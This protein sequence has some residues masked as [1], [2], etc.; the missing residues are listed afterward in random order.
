MAY[1]EYTMDSLETEF[2]IY[3]QSDDHYAGIEPVAVTDWLRESVR[4]GLYRARGI[5][6]EKARSELLI[7]PVLVEAVERCRDTAT[8]FSGVDFPVDSSR[9]LRGVVDFLISLSREQFVVRSPVIAIVEAKNENIKSGIA[10]CVAEMVAA[11]VFNRDRGSDLRTVFGVV[12]T[13]T[14][15]QFM[16]LVDETVYIEHNEYYLKEVEKVVAI[17]IA[18]IR[19]A[20]A[21]VNGTSQCEGRPR[22]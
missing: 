7:M 10:Q 20:E 18:M 2:R 22:Q 5:G 14:D 19:E 15:W 3:T 21:E 8:V 17:L 4:L 1:N 11:R 9:G 6:T 13:G 12:T 16:R